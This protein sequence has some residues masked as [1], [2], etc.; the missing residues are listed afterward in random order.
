MFH[1]YCS[2]RYCD[3]LRC[4]LCCRGL[5]NSL[6]SREFRDKML[7]RQTMKQNPQS[8]LVFSA[9]KTVLC[10]LSLDTFRSIDFRPRIETR[11]RK[12]V[13]QMKRVFSVRQHCTSVYDMLQGS[14]IFAFH[15]VMKFFFKNLLFILFPGMGVYG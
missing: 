9:T 14:E 1:A 11:G 8:M 10:R 3:D 4:H 12:Q 2:Q 5:P 15:G 13:C 7:A 6:R